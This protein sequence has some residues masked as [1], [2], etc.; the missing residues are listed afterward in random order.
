MDV[1][2]DRIAVLFPPALWVVDI[3]EFMTLLPVD[4]PVL[5]PDEPPEPEDEEEGD[6]ALLSVMRMGTLT[7]V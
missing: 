6:A 7:V 5:L 1:A 4:D 3:V 2:V